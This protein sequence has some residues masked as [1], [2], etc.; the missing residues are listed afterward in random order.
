MKILLNIMKFDYGDKKRGF[1]FEYENFYLTL[2][3]MGHDVDVFDFLT[4]SRAMGKERMNEALILQTCN[5]R[6]DMVMTSFF[7]DEF[8]PKFLGLLKK[9]C[10]LSIAW[11]NDDEWRWHT[12]GKK[13][14]HY[15]HYT[16]TTDPEAKKKYNSIGYTGAILSQFACNTIL[17]ENICATQDIDVSF[18]GQPNPWRL[19]VAKYLQKRGTNLQCFGYGWPNGRI[20]SKQMISIF[21]RS[22]I[23]LN[24]SNS[25]QYDLNYLTNINFSWQKH[26]SIAENIYQIF[27]PQIN[28]LL[29]PK[30]NEQ[31]KA[32][33]FEITGSGGFAL[34][35]DVKY[36]S[37]YFNLSKEIQTYK[38]PDDLLKKINFFL[39]NNT[40]REKIA[41]MGYKRTIYV[42]IHNFLLIL[43]HSHTF[44][45]APLLTSTR[46]L[47]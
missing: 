37:N 32:R 16:I 35:Y 11:M 26:K 47:I 30:K 4:I 29:S 40:M 1:S 19:Y 42:L 9:N 17:S 5:T 22:K 36:L 2:L 24:L 46:T 3:A 14:C 28:T 45:T 33:V 8:S 6:Y 41:K 20:T 23:N 44:I 31:I 27:G 7:K 25:V 43:R 38:S 21:N 15:F 12:L 13:I 10:K 39:K 18:I 34:T